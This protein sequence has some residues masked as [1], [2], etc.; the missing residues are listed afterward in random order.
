MSVF[1]EELP[2]GAAT[3][4][5]RGRDLIAETPGAW[6]F[7]VRTP[8]TDAQA[9]LRRNAWGLVAAGHGTLCAFGY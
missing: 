1:K 8:H 5:L 7:A 2:S 3:R 4:V 6:A 9:A